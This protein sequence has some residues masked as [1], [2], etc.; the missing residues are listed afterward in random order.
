M[1]C[2]IKK[3]F[4]L[5]FCHYASMTCSEHF[6]IQNLKQFS[7]L[8]SNRWY[9]FFFF[10]FFFFFLVSNS[11]NHYPHTHSHKTCAP[12]FQAKSWDFFAK[13]TQQ[14]SHSS[15]D[16]HAPL[17]LKRRLRVFFAQNSSFSRE[18]WTNKSDLT[19][20]QHCKDENTSSNLI[21]N[22]TL[23]VSSR[24]EIWQIDDRTISGTKLSL[25][26]ICAA[27]TRIKQHKGFTKFPQRWFCFVTKL[28]A[29]KV[30]FKLSLTKSLKE[31][32]SEFS[33]M[34]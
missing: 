27:R 3:S 30:F 13:N 32:G 23:H 20:S 11:C 4:P 28:L 14:N 8:R 17:L 25:P 31:T 15:H 2:C 12:T 19:C 34:K 21:V 9:L 6:S 33:S 26:L 7:R 1:N 24:V 10:F 5:P 16:R 22:H 29:R 18:K